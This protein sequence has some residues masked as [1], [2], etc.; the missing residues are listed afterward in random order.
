MLLSMI[1]ECHYRPPETV[2]RVPLTKEYKHY[3]I[4]SSIQAK[5][6]ERERL[7][8]DMPEIAVKSYKQGSMLL[9]SRDLD[10]SE[11]ISYDNTVNQ[12]EDEDTDNTDNN[13]IDISECLGITNESQSRS[14][15][16]VGRQ[17]NFDI[18]NTV[19]LR[20]CLGLQSL[21]N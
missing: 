7:L 19:S 8:R 16:H 6:T 17:V 12:P 18:A 4:L 1:M 15:Y 5:P 3:F 20:N 11:V 10:V 2:G 21:K 9:F 14:L 13:D